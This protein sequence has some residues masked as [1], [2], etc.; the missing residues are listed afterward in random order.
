MTYAEGWRLQGLGKRFIGSINETLRYVTK[1]PLK[2]TPSLD[3]DTK[4]L[5][6]DRFIYK[7]WSKIYIYF[8]RL[9]GL[10]VLIYPCWQPVEG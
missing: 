10:I 2:D 6:Q 4:Y 3:P 7:S 5:G 9:R 1:V 8:L